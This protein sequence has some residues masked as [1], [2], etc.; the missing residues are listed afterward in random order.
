M[1]II[2]IINFIVVVIERWGSTLERPGQRDGSQDCYKQCN[3]I[4]D[5]VM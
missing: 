5:V 4:M 3:R 1:N 2:V